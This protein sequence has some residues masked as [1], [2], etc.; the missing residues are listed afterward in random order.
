M[1]VK[2]SFFTGS[3]FLAAYFLIS[4]GIPVFAVLGGCGL[5]ALATWWK[6]SRSAPQKT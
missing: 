3:A 6:L 1:M 4:R 5:A 2:W